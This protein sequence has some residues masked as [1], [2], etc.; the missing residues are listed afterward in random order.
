MT[1]VRNTF[2]PTRELL[3]MWEDTTGPSVTRSPRQWGRPP[4]NPLVLCPLLSSFES[5]LISHPW[6][7]QYDIFSFLCRFNTIIDTLWL[8]SSL[9]A[10]YSEHNINSTLKTKHLS[11]QK[12][13]AFLIFLHRGAEITICTCIYLLCL[14]CS[15]IGYKIIFLHAVIVL[16][17]LVQWNKKCHWHV[18]KG[19]GGLWFVNVVALNCCIWKLM[20]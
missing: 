20:L 9:W 11:A 8:G 14:A 3:L 5:L 18:F 4:G 10:C 19:V 12:F 2:Y 17:G 7:D 16:N 6:S 13:H 15:F 1:V